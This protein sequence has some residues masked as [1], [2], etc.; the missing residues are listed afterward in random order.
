MFTLCSP[1][2]T[3][4]PPPPPSPR[5]TT[6]ADNTP[7][8]LRT[9]LAAVT[10]DGAG[11]GVENGEDIQGD[12]YAGAMTG[13][14]LGL[15]SSDGPSALGSHL[16]NDGD[17]D[18]VPSG[19]G[20]SF[21]DEG[22]EGAGEGEEPEDEDLVRFED[23]LAF[24][25]ALE[26]AWLHYQS[27]HIAAIRAGLAQVPPAVCVCVPA[28]RCLHPHMHASHAALYFILFLHLSP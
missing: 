20:D 10:T 7:I 5:T 11:A 24:A 6:L 2:F 12:E 16:W 19:L 8:N 26:Y 4:L 21:G 9:F 15:P 27:Q 18:G 28:A 1:S 17:D 25:D 22:T 23:R 3:L 14:S 13:L